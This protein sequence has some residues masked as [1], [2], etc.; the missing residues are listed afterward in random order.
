MDKS[1]TTSTGR[2]DRIEG[3]V[4]KEGERA[5]RDWKPKC[6]DLNV[7]GKAYAETVSLPFLITKGCSTLY[8]CSLA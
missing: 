7:K 3:A 8:A 2:R 4:S 1:K 6:K 5:R